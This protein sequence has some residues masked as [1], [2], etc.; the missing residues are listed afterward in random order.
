MDAQENPLANTVTYGIHQ[1]HRFHTLTSHFYVSRPIFLHRPAF[2]GWPA[3]LRTAMAA[4]VREA[5]ACQRR[6]AIEEEDAARTA[7]EAA[8]GE[9][10]A[11]TA[12]EHEAVVAAV[13]PI[14]DEARDRYGR[15]LLDLLPRA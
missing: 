8:R 4:A 10:I 7:I 3:E 6:L 5:V 9:I 2:D 15:G 14:H 1:H 12:A 13:R 11:L